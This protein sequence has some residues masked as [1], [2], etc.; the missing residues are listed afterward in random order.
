MGKI[1][2]YLEMIEDIQNRTPQK[3]AVCTGSSSLTYRE[4]FL[5]VK[6][7][8]KKWKPSAK[9]QLYFIQKGAGFGPANRVFNLSGNGLCASDPSKRYSIRS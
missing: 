5:L 8:Q 6:E 9:K 3:E 2:N 7:K 4:L 1:S